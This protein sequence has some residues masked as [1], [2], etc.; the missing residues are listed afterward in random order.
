MKLKLHAILILA[1]SLLIALFVHP[2]AGFLVGTVLAQSFMARVN[3]HKM[4]A[5]NTI[6]AGLQIDEILDAA[7]RAFMA[8][9]LPIRG[10]CTAF[11]DTMLKG[12][13]KVQVPYYPL[14]TAASKDY[15]GTYVFEPGDTQSREITINKRKYQPMAFTS[16]EL[17]RQPRLNPEELG[18]MK[19]QKLAEDVVADILSLVTAANFG[20]AGFTGAANT[21]DSDETADLQGA[22]D[23]ANWPKAGRSLI[24][25]SAFMTNLRKDDTIKASPGQAITEAALKE[26]AVERLNGFD[27]RPTNLIP[28]NGENLAGLAAYMSAILVGFSPIEP[29]AEVR[30]Q[31]SDY[32]SVTDPTSGLT[33]EYRAWGTPGSDTVYRVIEANYGYAKGEAAAIKRIVTA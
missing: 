1:V 9:I 31:M 4:C 20:V 8:D 33:L 22:C 21:F 17:A 27:L 26:G 6:A 16:A 2:V 18:R 3:G 12:T 11:Y 28:A 5:A 14:E 25:S 10:L 24:L 30:A 23:V 32:R 19:G 13:D 15:D 7:L 29:A